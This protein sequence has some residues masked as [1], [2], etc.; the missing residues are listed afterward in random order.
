MCIRDSGTCEAVKDSLE[1]LSTDRVK[2]KVLSSG[3]GAPGESD[4]HLAK[5][6]NAIIVGFNVRPDPAAR[7]SAEQQGVDIRVYQIIYELLDEVRAAMA[8]LLPPTVKEVL[9][10]RAE[11]RQPFTIP[12]IGTIGGSM[13]TEGLIR[14]GARARLIRDGVQIYDGR[15]GSLRR[16][17]DDA[18]EVLKDFECGIGIEG[19]N[20]L[21]IGDV[22]E[23]YDLEEHAAEL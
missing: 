20:D 18:R 1:K 8:G 22:I 2:L 21:K 10:G 19:Y 17:K 3:V 12:K 6:S 14:R 4:V 23:A 11:V 16:F 13:V 9:L 15:V 7:R 5:A